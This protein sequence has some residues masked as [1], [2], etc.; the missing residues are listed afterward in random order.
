[1]TWRGK[2]SKKKKTTYHP[3]SGVPAFQKEMIG[4]LSIDCYKIPAESSSRRI[5]LLYQVH[6]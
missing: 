5:F 6:Y 4:F 2:G 1:M 3:T